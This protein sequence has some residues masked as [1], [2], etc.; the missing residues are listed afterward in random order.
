M[1]ET[2]QFYIFYKHIKQHLARSASNLLVN[3]INHSSTLKL[4]LGAIL[5]QGYLYTRYTLLSLS[6][7]DVS[8]NLYVV[9]GV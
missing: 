7:Y 1:F 2:T 9:V 8:T 3:I 5:N 4:K 6:P